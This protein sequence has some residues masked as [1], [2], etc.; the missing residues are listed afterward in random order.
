MEAVKGLGTSAIERC[1]SALRVVDACALDG[2]RASLDVATTS[3]AL[4]ILSNSQFLE[5]RVGEEDDETEDEDAGRRV[6][7]DGQGDG[8]SEELDAA[9]L[10]RTARMALDAVRGRWAE[11]R[12]GGLALTGNKYWR[13]LPVVIGTSA[14]YRDESCGLDPYEAKNPNPAR[15]GVYISSD[16]EDSSEVSDDSSD[17]FESDI[18][19]DFVSSTS[20]EGEYSDMDDHLADVE[21][22]PGIL[23]AHGDEHTDAAGGGDLFSSVGLSSAVN[24]AKKAAP[25]YALSFDDVFGH[26]IRSSA[27]GLF[28]SSTAS[29]KGGIFDV[30][31]TSGV[32]VSPSPA[33]TPS[34]GSIPPKPAAAK[35]P[36][37]LFDSDSDSD[38]GRDLF[39]V[40]KRGSG[41]DLFSAPISDPLSSLKTETPAAKEA[42]LEPPTSAV[43]AMT[44]GVPKPKSPLFDESDTD[45]EG[46]L[47]STKSITSK[48]SFNREG[49]FD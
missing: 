36:K 9:E 2:E 6:G 15:W 48:P 41:G 11:T 30:A 43:G 31:G 1:A 25:S 14:Y 10:A 13:P 29:S 4:R 27:G 17:T 8:E 33:E 18:S 3:D 44:L 45:E 19:S 16:D 32:A 49:L 20:S 46:D 40:S 23:D 24:V 42:S 47:F 38:D 34:S 37:G 26:D 35:K 7:S 39:G 12:D 28:D 5:Q 22:Y 21:N